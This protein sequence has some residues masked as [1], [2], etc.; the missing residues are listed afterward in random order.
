MVL[1]YIQHYLHTRIK[2]VAGCAQ[3]ARID[4]LTSCI[5]FRQGVGE[6]CLVTALCIT[7]YFS[8][9]LGSGECW[10]GSSLDGGGS[11]LAFLHSSVCWKWGR[12]YE[13]SRMIS[14][15][16]VVHVIHIYA[17]GQT[18]MGAPTC[19]TLTGLQGCHGYLEIRHPVF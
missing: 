7:C 1:Q 2:Q 16:L 15:A 6:W 17:L 11:G 3:C 8:C 4:F 10:Y 18:V 12:F 19:E 13:W 14:N 5:S 9:A